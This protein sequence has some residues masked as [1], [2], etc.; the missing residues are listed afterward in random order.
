MSS[1]FGPNF[2]RAQATYEAQE[3]PEDWDCDE[4]GHDWRRL[5]GE[6]EDGTKFAR[7]QKCLEIR[8]L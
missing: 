7:C 4:D 8:E 3:P 5:P 1:E 2:D 6:S